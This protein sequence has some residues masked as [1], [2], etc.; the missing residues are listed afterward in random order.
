MKKKTLLQVFGFLALITPNTY[1]SEVKFHEFTGLPMDLQVRVLSYTDKPGNTYTLNKAIHY[2]MKQTFMW[3]KPDLELGRF[4]N[5]AVDDQQNVNPEADIF[6][7]LNGRAG[8]I[9]LRRLLYYAAGL[10]DEPAKLKVRTLLT[11]QV[12]DHIFFSRDTL[13][14]VSRHYP[15]VAQDAIDLARGERAYAV[16]LVHSSQMPRIMKDK[17]HEA[18]VVVGIQREDGIFRIWRLSSLPE[19]NCLTTVCRPN[20]EE[21]VVYNLTEMD[22]RIPHKDIRVVY[23]DGEMCDWPIKK[24]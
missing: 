8:Q 20:T 19:L 4:V 23:H 9:L 14:E 5:D 13:I 3:A 16:P 21:Y 12:T 2:K 15:K 24:G 18:E 10:P 11:R 1:A 22:G 17:L 6:Q 7:A